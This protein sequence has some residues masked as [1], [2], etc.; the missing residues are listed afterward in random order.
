MSRNGGFLSCD[1]GTSSFRIRWVADGEIAREFHDES[2]CRSIHQEAIASGES[3]AVLYERFLGRVLSKWPPSA[4]PLPLVISGMASSSIGWVELPYAKAPLKLDATDLRFQ[5]VEWSKPAWVDGTF[6]ISG[7]ATE[8]EI[9]RGEETEAIGLIDEVNGDAPSLL[10]LPGTHSKHLNIADG[11]IKGFSTYMTGELFD[12]LTRHSIL[13]STVD[14]SEIDSPAVDA[15]EAGI[16][17]AISAGLGASLFQTRT[18]A[19]LKGSPATQNASFLSG[20]LIGAEL[21]D[22]VRRF[23]DR[24]IVIAGAKRL[25]SLYARAMRLI[26]VSPWHEC[27]ERAVEMAVPTAHR[28]FLEQHGLC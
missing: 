7:L 25:R 14:L 6:L 13:K 28:L 4:K 15:F 19:I 8:N 11:E 12:V 5:R 1:W 22:S 2:G 20:V 16:R 23:P 21:A 9:M 24:K 27:E 3:P 10:I 17:Q 18:R 26:N